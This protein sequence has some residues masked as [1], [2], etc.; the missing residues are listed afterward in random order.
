MDNELK[1]GYAFM[2]DGSNE[3]MKTALKKSFEKK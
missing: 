1:K 2:F 3:N